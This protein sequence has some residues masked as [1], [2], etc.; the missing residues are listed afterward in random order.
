[1]HYVSRSWK[2]RT[3]SSLHL[4]IFLCNFEVHYTIFKYNV[5]LEKYMDLSLRLI[6]GIES[7]D[8]KPM[9]RKERSRTQKKKLNNN[10]TY[11]S[12]Q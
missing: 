8:T 9:R 2:I 11:S 4:Y 12:I 7:K 1:M 5:C 6:S 10:L 3:L